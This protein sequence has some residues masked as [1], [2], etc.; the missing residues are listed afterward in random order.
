MFT[1]TNLP[2]FLKYK[3]NATLCQIKKEVDASAAR[4]EEALRAH[5]RALKQ[6]VDEG[7]VR[8]LAMMEEPTTAAC[9]AD[10]QL[11][12][13]TTNAPCLLD[14]P[15]VQFLQVAVLVESEALRWLAVSPESLVATSP[16]LSCPLN[17]EAVIRAS[18]QGFPFPVLESVR[19]EI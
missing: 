16:L 13:L 17:T 4:L 1:L 8:G 9:A 6:K 10:K 18:L 5:V 7:V 19:Y 2:L 14:S 3:T 15:E 11:S 12:H